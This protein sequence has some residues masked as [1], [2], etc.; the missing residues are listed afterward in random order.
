MAQA[1]SDLQIWT[2]IVT[3]IARYNTVLYPI[4]LSMLLDQLPESGWIV[5]R[6]FDTVGSGQTLDELPTKGNTRLRFD[7]GNK[8]IGVAGSD[9]E[10]TLQTY[11]ELME[12]IKDSEQLGV[13]GNIHYV[14]LRIIGKIGSRKS[15]EN[16]LSQWWS[17]HSDVSDIG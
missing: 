3:M 13:D 10:E 15:P 5:S 12:L 17:A 16:V 6:K 4:D 9:I 1:Q 8:T 7:Q 14:E 11:K 2:Q